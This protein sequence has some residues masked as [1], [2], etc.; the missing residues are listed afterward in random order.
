MPTI[1]KRTAVSSVMLAVLAFLCW[2]A[3][4]CGGD[5]PEEQDQPSVEATIAA[6]VAEIAATQEAELQATVP[7]PAPTP[8]NTPAP[9]PTPTPTVPPTPT[10]APTATPAAPASDAEAPTEPL[11]PLAISD[12]GAFLASVSDAERTCLLEKFTLEDL[13][14]IAA[15]PEASTEAERRALIEC[16]DNET[17]LRLFLTPILYATG[18]LSPESSECMRSGFAEAD[19]GSVL[20]AAG[21]GAGSA[22]ANAEAAMARAMVSFMVSL[23]CLNE[24]EFSAASASMGAS[25]EEYQ[26][27]QC[28]L[29]EVGGPDKMAALMHPDAGLPGAAIRGGF[30]LPTRN[31]RPTAWEL[32]AKAGPRQTFPSLTRTQFAQSVIASEAWQSRCR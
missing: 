8:T 30:Q 28:V 32:A 11:T 16:L 24:S 27:F 25:P 14:S 17:T 31:V 20:V 26:N 1:H 12:P 13:A 3:I 15:S 29:E 6:V 2:S 4:G 18:P 23:S 5:D 21:G 10:D 19:L 7:A 9:V 22:D